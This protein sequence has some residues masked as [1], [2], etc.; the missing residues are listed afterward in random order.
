MTSLRL[1]YCGLLRLHFLSFIA[2]CIETID[3]GTTYR[4]NW[5]ILV[6]AHLGHPQALRGR[7][8]DRRG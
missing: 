4:E 6:L 2:K 7:C 3:P 8:L 1:I 5:H